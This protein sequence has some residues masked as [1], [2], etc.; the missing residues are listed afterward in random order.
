MNVSESLQHS[1]YHS[2]LRIASA[3]MALVLLFQSGLVNESTSK[4]SRGTTAYLANAVGMSAQVTPTELNQY[5]AALTEKEQELKARE[6]ALKERE[7]QVGLTGD[8]RSSETTTYI[9]ASIL[10]VLLLLILL[11]Y[12]LDYL[13][14]EE[15]VRAKT[16]SV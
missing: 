13:R 8:S 3:V 7:I 9:L 15:L 14:T 5:T 6:A 12:L 4:I 2:F 16:K 1:I 11:N 10:F